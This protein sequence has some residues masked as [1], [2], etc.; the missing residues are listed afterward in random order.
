[1]AQLITPDFLVRRVVNEIEAEK[2]GH[3][4]DNYLNSQGSG[5]KRTSPTPHHV[6]E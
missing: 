6:F 2:Q 3:R 1:M 4:E 5:L